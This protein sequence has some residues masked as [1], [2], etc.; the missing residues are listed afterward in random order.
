MLKKSTV[1]IL[2]TIVIILTL[3]S[4]LKDYNSK[5]IYEENFVSSLTTTVTNRET[6][7]GTSAATERETATVSTIYS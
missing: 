3:A 2:C 5:K 4:C 7:Y 6:V 1:L